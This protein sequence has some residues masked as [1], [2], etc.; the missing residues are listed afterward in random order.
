MFLGLS[1]PLPDSDPRICTEMS[2]IPTIGHH[3]ETVPGPTF[4]FDANLNSDP[5]SSYTQVGKMDFFLLLFTSM[6][7][8]IVLC[9]SSMS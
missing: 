6:L 9:F 3:F 7:F 5:N 8:Y 2:R 1:D 4:H